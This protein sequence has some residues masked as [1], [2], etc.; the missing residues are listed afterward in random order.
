MVDPRGVVLLSFLWP[1]S[2]TPHLLL[3][4]CYQ[5]VLITLHLYSGVSWSYT[6]PE[7]CCTAPAP[8]NQHQH[9]EAGLHPGAPCAPPGPESG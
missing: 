5:E 8:A 2:L 6:H 3:C 1:L 9:H 4:L 7:G